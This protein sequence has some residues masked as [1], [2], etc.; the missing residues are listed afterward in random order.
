M[1]DYGIIDS[2]IHLTNKRVISN[3]SESI[4]LALDK[5]ITGFIGCALTKSDIQLYSELKDTKLH[6]TAGFHPY[7]KTDDSLTF[8]NIVK[9]CDQKKICGI[10]EIGLDKRNSDLESQVSLFKTQLDIAKQYNL[11]V[12]I[13]CV[14]SYYEILKI[15]KQDFPSI[16]GYFHS[17][18]GSTDVIDN[19]L[20]TN[21]M[22]STGNN[23][24]AKKKVLP[25]II[26]SGRYIFESDAPFTNGFYSTPHILKVNEIIN[27]VQEDRD[28]LIEI[29]Y[30]N[31]CE[32]YK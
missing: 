3:F 28:K 27:A 10:G 18:G 15:I 19:V 31:I 9:L 13:H 32:V 4:S 30:K 22:M 17:F 16:R 7:E 12:V 2:H 20:K 1:F 24:L 6:Y 26:K 5:N 25:E 8:D 14:K 11:P 21:L 23:T 29:Q